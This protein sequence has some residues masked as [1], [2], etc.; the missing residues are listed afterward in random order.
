[1]RP[2]HEAF[3]HSAGFSSQLFLFLVLLVCRCGA[4]GGLRRHLRRRLR[5]RYLPCP[6][7]WS[8]PPPP[9]SDSVGLAV[10]VLVPVALVDQCV[11]RGHCGRLEEVQR[12]HLA[13]GVGGLRRGALAQRDLS[14]G[15]GVAQDHRL[16]LLSELLAGVGRSNCK[17]G[18][19]R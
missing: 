19:T 9:S 10:V 6:S 8:S 5:H 16:V 14:H 1:M 3:L 4:T 2:S 7:S 11:I 15:G 18:K 17:E 12:V 13:Q